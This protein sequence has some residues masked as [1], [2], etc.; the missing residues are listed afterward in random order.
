[1]SDK[2]YKTFEKDPDGKLDYQNNWELEISPDTITEST[3]ES[4][5]G[6]LTLS[7]EANTDYTATVTVAG[8]NDGESHVAANHIVRASGL[9]DTRRIRFNICKQ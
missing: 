9:E 2:I 6:G 7:D 5:D 1:M 3:W 4:E 8:G